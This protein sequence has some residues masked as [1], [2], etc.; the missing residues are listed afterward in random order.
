M[1]NSGNRCVHMA[2]YGTDSNT[3]I[4]KSAGALIGNVWIKGKNSSSHPF[5]LAVK[6]RECGQI[7]LEDNILKDRTGADMEHV[8]NYI[9]LLDSPPLWPDGLVA[10]SA[11]EALH[12]VLKTAGAR[13]GER[14]A[15]D[16]RI[17][18]SVIDGTG[19]IID[20][21]ND[22][23]GYPS[24]T[25]TNRI[26]SVPGSE[27]D[28]KAWLDTLSIAIDTHKSLD[29]S[30]L[31]PVITAINIK[32]LQRYQTFSLYLTNYPNPFNP[33]TTIKFQLDESNKITL[34]IYN[35]TGQEIETIVNRYQT[36][37]EHEITW[38]PAGLPSGIY[39]YRL[40]AGEYSETKK[41]ILQK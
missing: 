15:I 29:T 30:P 33:L 18:Q 17:V 4:G 32:E 20:S 41:L 40:Q 27:A 28:R 21:E 37:G 5:V 35:I 38:Q 2:D 8:D 34:K 23:G 12:D 3:I 22:V 25:L 36:A 14:D 7:Y 13:A 6:N 26:I 11:N 1:Y 10:K 19:E 9:K 24:Y 31:T 16:T 39:F